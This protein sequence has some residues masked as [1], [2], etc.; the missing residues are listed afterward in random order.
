MSKNLSIIMILTIAVYGATMLTVMANNNETSENGIETASVHYQNSNETTVVG[1][2]NGENEISEEVEITVVAQETVANQTPDIANN[3]PGQ[4]ENT[5]INDNGE[6]NEPVQVPETIIETEPEV[7]VAPETQT[8]RKKKK[9]KHKTVIT[10]AAITTTT[11]QVTT[12]K[13]E[14]TKKQV[15]SVGSHSESNKIT[16][17]K[18]SVVRNS[19]TSNFS[20]Y[21]DSEKTNLARYMS[22][23]GK[24][25][26]KDAYKELTNSDKNLSSKTCSIS[27]ASDSQEDI[28]NA[29]QKA[30][31]SIGRVSGSYGIG[32]SSV[33]KTVGYKIYIVVVY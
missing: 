28:L 11:V 12:K 10:T 30:A 2:D 1:D 15:K 7:P 23:S 33:E 16:S 25:N 24:S 21:S 19:V 6:N 27:I 4:V 32:I 22:A 29:A 3:E 8:V 26:A 5:D 9:K 17:S 20:G 18:I 31:N 14:T 13:E